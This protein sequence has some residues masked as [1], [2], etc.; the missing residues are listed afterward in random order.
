[1]MSAGT[2]KFGYAKQCVRCTVPMVDQETGAKAC[3]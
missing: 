1:V 2:A 3:P